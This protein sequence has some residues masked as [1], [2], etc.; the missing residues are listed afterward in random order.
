[1]II[2]IEETPL[3]V[4]TVFYRDLA[5]VS[6]LARSRVCNLAGVYFS[7]MCIIFF[8]WDLAAVCSYWDVHYS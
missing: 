1:M 4:D 5:L 7:Q 6:S 8:A 3:K 2:C